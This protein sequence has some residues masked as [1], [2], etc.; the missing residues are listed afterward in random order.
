MIQDIEP[1]IFYNEFRQKEA[2]SQ[3]KIIL[4]SGRMVLIKRNQDNTLHLP[5][6]GELLLADAAKV[7]GEKKEYQYIFSIDS[8]EYFLKKFAGREEQLWGIEGYGW[9]NISGL[10]QM[11]SK[12]ICFAVMGAFQLYEWYRDNRFCGRCGK[13]M[14][15]SKEQRM[16]FCQECKN[17]VFP[18][19]AP[20]VIVGVVHQDKI[21]M[22][23]YAGREYKKY[24]LLAGFVEFGE[25][26][27][28]TVQREVMEE[29]GLKVKHIKYYKSQ[30]WGVDSNLLL[31]YFAELDGDGEIMLDQEELAS[32]EWFSREMMPAHNDGI[33]LTREMMGFFEQKEAFQR[34]YR[35]GAGENIYKTQGHKNGGTAISS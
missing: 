19:V 23:K 34:W 2:G 18:K 11:E 24:A 16:L 31:G 12:E 5:E 4:F 9:E 20:A 7:S 6:Y 25:T 3:S 13:E 1:K 10:R 33:S 26:S 30:P 17:T 14:I 29:V 22:S 21:L 15:H 35:E 8:D 28:Q 27:E 32:A